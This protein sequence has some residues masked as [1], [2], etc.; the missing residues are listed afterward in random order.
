M[1]TILALPP[2][3]VAVAED[4]GLLGFGLRLVHECMDVFEPPYF[5]LVYCEGEAQS[6]L[7]A[8]G[9]LQLL[10]LHPLCW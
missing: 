7:Q 3:E 8:F 1:G 6:V 5:S 10:Q 9:V 2:R 4:P